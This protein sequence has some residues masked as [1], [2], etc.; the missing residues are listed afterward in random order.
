MTE[1]GKTTALNGVTTTQTSSNV[2]IFPDY[3]TVQ[4]WIT[5]S[6]A[7]S[8]T[9]NIY[10]SNDSSQ[11]FGALVATIS[12]AGTGSDQV[13]G[14]IMQKWRYVWAQI[15]TI[16]GTNAGVWVTFGV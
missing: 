15:T 12:L 11:N 2:R 1:R 9:V 8:A 16:S 14:H 5:G 4:A 7:V 10:G 13:G 3:F 6:G